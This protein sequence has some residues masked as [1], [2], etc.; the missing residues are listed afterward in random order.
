MHFKRLSLYFILLVVISTSISE[1]T[2]I[3]MK[4]HYSI[5]NNSQLFLE[6][7]SHY[8]GVIISI[9][10]YKGNEHDIPLNR[11]ELLCLYNALLSANNWNKS[12]IKLLINENATQNAIVNAFNWLKENVDT[13]D[14]VIFSYLGHGGEIPDVNGDEKDGYDEG[15]IPWEGMDGFI[16]DDEL[17]KKFNEINAKGMCIIFDCCLSGDLID[18]KQLIKHK[19]YNKRKF[20]EEISMDIEANN[21]VIL[22][23]TMRNGLG[24]MLQIKNPFTNRTRTSFFLKWIAKAFKMKID[25]NNDEI[26]SAEEAFLFAKFRILPFAIF[27]LNPVWQ[28][29]AIMETGHP[30]LAFPQMYDGYEGDLPIIIK[31]T[32]R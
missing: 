20:L 12:H 24:G 16:S 19:I 11:S 25:F 31:N 22:T 6:N 30:I 28:L 27:L 2:I 10:D 29:K 5:R 18:K 8:W 23:S 4:N 1:E 3:S 32:G 21:R 9:G 15:I 7:E 17:G 13:Q 26:C 14:I